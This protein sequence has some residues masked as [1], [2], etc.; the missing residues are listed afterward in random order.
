MAVTIDNCAVILTRYLLTA[1][2][3]EILYDLV[4]SDYL[5]SAYVT[6]SYVSNCTVK[7]EV[8]MQ[9][10]KWTVTSHK[11][12]KASKLNTIDKPSIQV[13][14]AYALIPREDYHQ[15]AWLKNGRE[16]QLRGNAD[17]WALARTLGSVDDAALEETNMFP[18]RCQR[19]GS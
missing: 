14:G 11:S 5:V 10:L 6:G 3:L 17:D 13:L 9:V 8:S 19:L 18:N 12:R 16:V 1:R 15:N 2:E 4:S 7:N